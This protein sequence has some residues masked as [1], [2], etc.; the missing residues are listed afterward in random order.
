MHAMLT[1]DDITFIYYIAVRFSEG[2]GAQG[3][4]WE[5]EMGVSRQKNNVYLS[6]SPPPANSH[7][8]YTGGE[9]AP[10]G[11]DYFY[12]NNCPP[13]NIG[14]PHSPFLTR[15][16]PAPHPTKEWLPGDWEGPTSCTTVTSVGAR[17]G[18][19]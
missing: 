9:E 10:G 16:P 13:S 7:D 4:G 1:D 12:P 8:S 17:R 14:L 3:A 15:L 18:K 19:S 6:N 11:R 2:C 5:M